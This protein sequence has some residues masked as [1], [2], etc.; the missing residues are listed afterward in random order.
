MN[1]Y[2]LGKNG[3]E[4]AQ[5]YITR[6]GYKILEINKKFPN[7]CEIDMIAL[8]K[9]TLV[10]IEVKTRKSTICG[11]PIEAIT[12]TKYYNIRQCL[13]LYLREHVEYKKYRIDAISIVL[14]P[15]VEIKHLKNI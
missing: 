7:R 10:F 2:I 8:D 3:E 14:K 5:K 6:Q 15:S 13:L 12:K 4:I 11:Q 1:N 9:Q